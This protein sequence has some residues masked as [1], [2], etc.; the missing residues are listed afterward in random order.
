MA[1]I[2]A[3]TLAVGQASTSLLFQCTSGSDLEVLALLGPHGFW[4]AWSPF[5]QRGPVTDCCLGVVFIQAVHQQILSNKFLIVRM[6]EL[7]WSREDCQKFYQEHE[8][9]ISPLDGRLLCPKRCARQV[10]PGHVM[11]GS[12][13]PARCKTVASLLK[14]GFIHTL[15]LMFTLFLVSPR[16]ALRL[17]ET[18][19]YVW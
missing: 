7:L 18:W 8:G 17:P 14:S 4:P 11:A 1:S 6:R 3:H 15:P 16:E 10:S 9:R 12:L 13:Q 5:I 19:L 2:Q